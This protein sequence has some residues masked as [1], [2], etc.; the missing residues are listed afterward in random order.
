MRFA[1]IETWAGPRA[2]LQ[3][4]GDFVDLHATDANVP[5]NLRLILE[6]GAP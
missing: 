2:C 3:T 5:P 6:G 1:T 4:G